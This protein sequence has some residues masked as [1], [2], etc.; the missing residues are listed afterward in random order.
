MERGKNE[1]IIQGRMPV[2]VVHQIRFNHV[3]DSTKDLAIRFGTTIGKIDDVKKSRNFAYVSENVKFTDDQIVE[4]VEWLKRHPKYDDNDI[5]ALVNELESYEKASEAEAQ[6]FNEARIAA[7]G[8]P[9]TNKDG[10]I[11]SGGGGNRRG[12]KLDENGNPIPKGKKSKKKDADD[13]PEPV[14][15]TQP[16]AEDE[17][18]A[19]DLL[20]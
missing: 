17:P 14:C 11:A 15:S 7:R 2:I 1:D 18:S 12:A 4:G 20:A 6:E 19:D 13:E 3:N 5:D 16:E 8:Q 9:T 10:S